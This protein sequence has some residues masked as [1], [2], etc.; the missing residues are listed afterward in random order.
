VLPQ[1][2]PISASIK[3]PY[4]HWPN[5]VITTVF[6]L[7]RVPASRIGCNVRCAC[8]SPVHRRRISNE[9]KGGTRV[10]WSSSSRGRGASA[11][12]RRDSRNIFQ[13]H[14][15]R[16]RVTCQKIRKH[17]LEGEDVGTTASRILL[18]RHSCSTHGQVRYLFRTTMEVI[19]ISGLTYQAHS[20]SAHQQRC[21]FLSLCLFLYF[22]ISLPRVSLYHLS[23][24]F[25]LSLFL[26]FIVL[27]PRVSLYSP[28]LC[29]SG[30]WRTICLWESRLYPKWNIH[31]GHCKIH[32][33]CVR[34]QPIIF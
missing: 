4:L 13:S 30:L 23:L 20:S 27:L 19:S 34:R 21:L 14:D 25:F 15:E 18:Y 9:G 22:I 5:W 24:F 17:E 33:E 26:Y 32:H 10:T 6:R 28:S 7:H 2:S 29:L 16:R 1:A 12:R 3:S 8:G 31:S 11:V